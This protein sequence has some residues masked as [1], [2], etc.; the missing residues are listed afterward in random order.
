MIANLLDD[1]AVAAGFLV[2]A[3]GPAV[4]E[5]C[6]GVL[7]AFFA[8]V[9]VVHH[10]RRDKPGPAPAPATQ[11]G[12]VYGSRR[13]FRHRRSLIRHAHARRTDKTGVSR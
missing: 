4:A 12:R 3:H 1:L 2:L 11:A 10:L 13:P 5:I 9:V 7:V 6:F 8:T